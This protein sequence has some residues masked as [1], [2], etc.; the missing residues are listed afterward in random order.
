MRLWSVPGGKLLHTMAGHGS[1]IDRV[2]FSPDGKQLSSVGADYTA[3]VWNA[4]TGA[5]VTTL[6]GHTSTINRARFDATGTKLV[7]TGDDHTTRVWDLSSGRPIEI[8][9]GPDAPMT[10]GQFSPDGTELAVSA[11]DGTIRIWPAK[12][13]YLVRSVPGCNAGTRWTLR[14]T[15]STAISWGAV[16]RAFDYSADRVVDLPA[17]SIAALST[18][19]VHVATGSA[20][21]VTSWSLDTRAALRTADAGAEVTALAWADTGGIAAVGTANGN[22][23]LWRPDR[24]AELVAYDHHDALVSA[25]GW[26]ANNILV[27]GDAHGGVHASHLDGPK[28][29]DAEGTS[30]SS[31]RFS[32]DGHIYGVAAGAAIHLRDSA[33]FAPLATLQHGGQVSEFIFDDRGE[34]IMSGANDGVARVWA[35]RD[36]TLIAKLAG[37]A[38]WL[39][40]P[41]FVGNT[42]AAASDLYGQVRFWD[43]A[44]AKLVLALSIGSEVGTQV[45]QAHTGTFAFVTE[46]CQMLE[47]G[48]RY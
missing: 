41:A 36:G 28:Q 19:G 39:I 21:T 46:D 15:D 44:R 40:G 35:A 18:D 3:R 43:I 30:I 34:R 33:T 4:S 10:R 9:V 42:L 1:Q 20:A 45:L 38:S 29:V 26:G 11:W 25:I 17:S 47:W 7:T 2:E 37:G 6:R 5:P 16:T 12:D 31:I 48:L 23:F 24:D 14:P 32:R 27:T 22:V 8:L 13:P